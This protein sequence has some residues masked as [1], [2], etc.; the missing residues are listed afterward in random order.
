MLN[1][2]TDLLSFESAEILH[3]SWN[4]LTE[5]SVFWASVMTE[6]DEQLAKD[7]RSV[8]LSLISNP[9]WLLCCRETGRFN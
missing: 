8:H 9:V 6:M 7:Q 2:V 5:Y 3:T 4:A 1:L